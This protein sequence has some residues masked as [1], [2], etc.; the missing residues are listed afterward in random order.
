ME[1]I[2]IIFLIYGS[3]FKSKNPVT[4]GPDSIRA[5]TQRQNQMP[6]HKIDHN[7]YEISRLV[8]RQSS[9]KNATAL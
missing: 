8:K 2:Y 1:S 3:L 4:A 6:G 5:T 7:R 9:Q